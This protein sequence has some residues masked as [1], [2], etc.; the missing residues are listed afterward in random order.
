MPVMW[1]K[2]ACWYPVWFGYGFAINTTFFLDRRRRRWL[3][4][5][6][7]ANCMSPSLAVWRLHLFVMDAWR[8]VK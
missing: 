5:N 2:D 7:S 3:L 4:F 8:G 1:C 6:G